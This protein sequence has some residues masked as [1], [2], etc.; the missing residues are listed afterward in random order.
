MKL[1]KLSVGV[2]NAPVPVVVIVT[3]PPVLLP[4]VTGWPLA[5][6]NEMAEIGIFTVPA[7]ALAEIRTRA[8]NKLPELIVFW[9]KP[10]I[11]KV[12]LLPTLLVLTLLL[13]LVRMEPAVTETVL[14]LGG[15]V[16]LN[17][18]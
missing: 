2:G 4:P 8:V 6:V 13:A 10:K 9:F 12:Q 16:R 1:G 5:L 14:I 17:W 15:K 7:V 3:L 11:I 18:I